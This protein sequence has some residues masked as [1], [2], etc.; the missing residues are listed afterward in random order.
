MSGAAGPTTLGITTAHAVEAAVLVGDR[1]VAVG[2]PGQALD[3]LLERVQDALARARVALD[4]VALVAVCI[5]PGSFT[6][7]RI[8]VSFAKALAQA[9]E[10]PLVGVTSHDVVERRV[11]DA[12]V[13]VVAGKRDCFYARVREA[14]AVRY[15]AGDANVLAAAGV[16]AA[17]WPALAEGAWAERVARIGRR[18]Y[19]AKASADWRA[20]ALEYGQRPSAETNWQWQHAGGPAAKGRARAPRES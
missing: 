2:G 1:A 10:L 18:A 12:A 11:G 4:D 20:L 13:A 8:G 17:A 9:R 3:H 14:E 16:D 19:A 5:G 7:L 15:V 6:G